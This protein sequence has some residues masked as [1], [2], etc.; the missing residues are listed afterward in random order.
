MY[1]DL[2]DNLKEERLKR[3]W[4]Q[5]DVCAKIG[6]ALITYQLWERGISTP[7]PRNLEKIKE[8]FS[9]PIQK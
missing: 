5:M 7:F 1:M 2:M 4:S 3:G 9:E 8:V 6:V